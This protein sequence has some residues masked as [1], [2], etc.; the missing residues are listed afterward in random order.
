MIA[1]EVIEHIPELGI[2]RDGKVDSLQYEKLSVLLL[3][4]IKKLNERIKVL[5]G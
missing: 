3:E 1:E 4:E 5:E 2:Y